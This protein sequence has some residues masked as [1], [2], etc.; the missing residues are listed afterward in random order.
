METIAT[1]LISLAAV[2][3]LVVAVSWL[4]LGAAR[5]SSQPMPWLMLYAATVP[6]AAIVWA[7][8]VDNEGELGYWPAPW[9]SLTLLVAAGVFGWAFFSEWRSDRQARPNPDG[10]AT[11]GLPFAVVA[12]QAAATLGAIAAATVATVFS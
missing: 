12:V 10:A 3:S 2:G 4:L 5:R 11:V 9:L 7:V 1:V 8:H 6:T